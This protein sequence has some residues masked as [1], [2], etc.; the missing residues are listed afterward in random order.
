MVRCQPCR[1]LHR[2][3]PTQSQRVRLH[4][5]FP[6]HPN[7]LPCVPGLALQLIYTGGTRR[8]IGCSPFVCLGSWN[9]FWFSSRHYVLLSGRVECSRLV[10]SYPTRGDWQLLAWL[11]WRA[12][13]SY[14]ASIWPQWPQNIEVSLCPLHIVKWLRRL[15]TV[16]NRP[17]H[18]GQCAQKCWN[19]FWVRG[20]V[21]TNKIIMMRLFLTIHRRR[22]HIRRRH[23]T[24]NDEYSVQRS[25]TS[26]PDAGGLTLSSLSVSNF[27]AP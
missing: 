27:C 9:V 2:C 1:W 17:S 18:V 23:D 10:P 21:C 26:S 3:C 11:M 19:V 12:N 24:V 22:H 7:S 14:T 20:I 16:W 25:Q 5:A 4:R 15:S 13:V 8:G 6:R